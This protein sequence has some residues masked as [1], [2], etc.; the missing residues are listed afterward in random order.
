MQK[1]SKF[2]YLVVAGSFLFMFLT[3]GVLY[4]FGVFFNSIQTQFGWSR[5]VI[6]GAFSL[7]TL[8]S[9]VVGICAG[10]AADKYGP[11]L[12]AVI[13]TIALS[14]GYILLAFT[15]SLGWFYV[16]H[17][18]LL[19]VGVGSAMPSM[20]PVIGNY[21]NKNRGFM[22]GLA[23]SGIGVAALVICPLTR[24][25]ITAYGW[26][27]AYLIL[28]IAIFIVLGATA[29]LVFREVPGSRRRLEQAVTGASGA[30]FGETLHN[31]NFY[32]LCALY[33]LFGYS[34]QSIMV[35]IIPYATDLGY[36]AF[37]VKMIAV[38]GALNMLT[39]IT[40]AWLSD[41]LGV[42][43]TL[44]IHF[45][46]L[47]AAFCIILLPATLG[48]L[49]SFAVLFGLAYGGIMV[50]TTISVV[51]Y[52]GKRSSGLLLGVILMLNTLGGAIGPLVTGVIFDIAG[53]YKTAFGIC[54]GIAV[55]TLLLTIT[56]SKPRYS[57]TAK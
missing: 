40:G 26:R 11:F 17:V 7:L 20:L 39:R 2:G 15:K 45:A 55:I 43:L 57:V 10:R 34:L 28:G 36:T 49:V 33:F 46:F 41:R 53:N 19:A 35:H 12:P 42:K 29:V 13:I 23:A 18:A 27:N 5:G 30:T 9:G 4:N 56:L 44:I 21:F 16:C 32:I 54:F 22:I 38:I 52:F 51:D 48:M 24:G 25:L 14:A 31:R 8:F 1:S 47:C 6:S 37:A 3:F 50:L